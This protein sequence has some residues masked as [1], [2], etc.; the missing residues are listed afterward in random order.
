MLALAIIAVLLILFLC[1]PVGADIRYE[2]DF[3]LKL[4]IGF[5]RYALLP[6]KDKKK[7]KEKK[8]QQSDSAENPEKKK[9][10]APAKKKLKFTL[11][12]IQELLRIAFA[13]LGRFRRSLS[14]DLFRLHILVAAPDPY[15]AV[16][17]FGALNAALGVLAGPAHKALKIRKEDIRTDVNV[18]SAEGAVSLQLVATLQIWEILRIALCAAYALLRWWL[19]KKKAAKAAKTEETVQ[20]ES[21][22]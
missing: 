10:D 12:D 13:A 6:A 20:K 14:I 8:N 7:Q 9:K 18:Q 11:Q 4:K 17:R 22:S 21:V 16:V 2:D 1:I 5:L 3:Q 19:N 15:D